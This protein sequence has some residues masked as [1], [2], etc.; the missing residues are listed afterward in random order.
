MATCWIQLLIVVQFKPKEK[1]VLLLYF[2]FLIQNDVYTVDN[3]KLRLLFFPILYNTLFYFLCNN[4][5][6]TAAKLPWEIFAAHWLLLVLLLMILS[7]TS[8]FSLFFLFF[9]YILHFLI[10]NHFFSS[11]LFFTLFFSTHYGR[12]VEKIK[13]RKNLHWKF[14]F[15]I[16]TKKNKQTN[17]LRLYWLCYYVEMILVQIVSK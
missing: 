17:K 10:I 7:S 4:S 8:Y 6:I 1:Y 13:Q 14:E 5:F 15:K 9:F 12:D 2:F 16:Q 3:C 11:L